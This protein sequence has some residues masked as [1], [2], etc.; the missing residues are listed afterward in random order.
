[1]RTGSTIG[2]MVAAGLAMPA[3][4]VG[5]PAGPPRVFRTG[6]LLLIHA[7]ACRLR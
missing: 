7:A 1:M 3:V 5:M 6:E 4:D 2:P